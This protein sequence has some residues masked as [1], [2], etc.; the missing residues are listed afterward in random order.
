[1]NGIVLLIDHSDLSRIVYHALAKE[2]RIDV[3]IREAKIPRSI[4]LKRRLKR[5]GWRT[6]AGQILF[7]A[8]MVPLLKRESIQRRANIMQQYGM[9]ESPIPA[10]CI[11]D[12][13]SVNDAQVITLLQ[14][15]SPRVIVVNG[16]RIL[17]EKV[18][19]TSDGVFLNTHVGITPLYRGVH[20]GYWAQA[21]G[22]PEHFGVTI[23]KI[24]KGIDT[25]EIVAQASDRPASSDNFSTYPLL[26]IA[27]AIPILKQAIRNALDGKL[28]TLSAPAGKSKLWTHPTLFQYLKHRIARGI[29]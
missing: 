24:D 20:G 1:M 19:Q 8:G 17:E 27:L 12:V 14:K 29:R 11:T 10:E 4:F 26:Q 23:H 7:A 9:D 15:L 6:L 25:G 2:F 21:S 16:T 18:L 28:E 22:D 5:L 13:L 3:V